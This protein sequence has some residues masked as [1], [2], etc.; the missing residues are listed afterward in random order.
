MQLNLGKHS[1]A[2]AVAILH[3]AGIRSTTN[4]NM[5]NV[6]IGNNAVAA[7]AQKLLNSAPI[8]PSATKVDDGD[9]D[10]E[11]AQLRKRCKELQGENAKLRRQ[12]Q[13][14]DVEADGKKALAAT[15]AIRSRA[16]ALLASG[17]LP[18]EERIDVEQVIRDCNLILEGKPVDSERSPGPHALGSLA[19]LPPA[20]RN[21]IERPTN[22]G[23]ASIDHDGISLDCDF[24]PDEAQRL[25][26]EMEGR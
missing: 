26:A 1:Y 23:R 15:R 6:V 20:F 17:E 18:R 25:L 7:T 21:I 13:D 2:S 22:S 3:D 19:L 16:Q 8:H 11:V 12:L 4:G 9:D 10:N 24:D 14:G 5:K